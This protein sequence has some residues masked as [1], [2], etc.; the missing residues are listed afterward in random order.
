MGAELNYLLLHTKVHWLSH[1][2]VLHQIY[3]LREEVIKL[4]SAKK[5]EL[6]SGLMMK[7]DKKSY[8]TDIFGHL[9]KLNTNMQG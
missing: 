4:I 3:V 7:S 6:T 5:L 2:K 9:N 8:L 1:G